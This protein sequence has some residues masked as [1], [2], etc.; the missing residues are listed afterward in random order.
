M[1]HAQSKNVANV[2]F[3]RVLSIELKNR[4]RGCSQIPLKKKKK[5]IYN[6]LPFIPPPNS[7]EH[8]SLHH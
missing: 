5:K 8:M 6:F 2:R 1:L 3:G 7:E 4:P